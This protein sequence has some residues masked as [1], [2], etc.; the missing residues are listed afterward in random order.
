MKY[1][2]FRVRDSLRQEYYIFN[3]QYI[4]YIDFDSQYMRSKA[5]YHGYTEDQFT[6]ALIDNGN[7][8]TIDYSPKNKCKRKYQIFAEGE[9]L[10]HKI[11]RKFHKMNCNSERFTLRAAEKYV[12]EGGL[13]ISDDETWYEVYYP[14]PNSSKCHLREVKSEENKLKTIE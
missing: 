2:I 9:V 10:D 14:S 8:L 5:E 3:N 12:K 7:M 1:Y 13:T 11:E 6:E 4:G